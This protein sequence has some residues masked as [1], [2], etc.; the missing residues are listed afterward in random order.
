MTYANFFCDIKLSK[1]ETHRVCLK[2]GSNK[3][4]YY[5]DPS[6]SA[7]SL[8]DLKIH[9][10]SVISD[11]RK[12]DRYLTAD[13][14][15]YYLNNSMANYQY[16]QIHLR[17][18][19]NEV[20]IEYSLLPIADSSGYIYV[21]I[22]KGMY[23]IKESGIIAYKRLVR[24]LQSHCY[25]PVAHTPGIWTHANLSTTF[26]LAVD[27]FGIKFFA[28]DDATH[29]LDALR[30]NY[31]ITVDTSDSKY[32][33]LTI[34][35]NYPGNYVA[36]SMPN[37]V[38]KALERLQHPMPTRPRHSPHKWLATTYGAKVQ[39]SPNATTKPKYDKYSITRMQSIASTFLYISCA[40]GPKTRYVS[41]RS[42]AVGLEVADKALVGDDD[43]L[44]V[45]VNPLSD[46]N[47]DK[48]A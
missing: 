41:H 5:S 24:N 42:I 27:D 44:L 1:T 14:I 31:S 30:E 28:A 23:G 45:S 20:V 32:C 34:K 38:C 11:T 15:N 13:I 26:T 33:G 29:L 43:G 17:D 16:M 48:A 47:V 21:E 12:G 10:N 9:I 6:S 7:I 2:V 22:K 4:T 39:Y 19:P 37:S 3:L 46:L 36:I 35:W 25:A 40:V 18:I 8:L